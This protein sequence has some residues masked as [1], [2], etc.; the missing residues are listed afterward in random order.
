MHNNFKKKWPG[1]FFKDV[2]WAAAKA[3]T[4]HEFEEAMEVIRY[5]NE[6]A[7]TYLMKQDLK[8][9][10]LHGFRYYPKSKFN[11]IMHVSHSIVAYLKQG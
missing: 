5:M 11:S 7:A 10:S 9:W 8:T 1:K 2:V 3:S 6:E 4:L